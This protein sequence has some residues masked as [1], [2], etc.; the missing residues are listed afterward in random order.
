[1]SSPRKPENGFNWDDVRRQPPPPQGSAPARRSEQDCN[2][3]EVAPEQM[4][5]AQQAYLARQV[6][7][8][9]AAGKRAG[10]IG[11]W[12]R[13]NGASPQLADAFLAELAE[14]RQSDRWERICGRA[15]L[16]LIGGLS[17]AVLM[18]VM[19]KRPWD[20]TR[21]TWN[22]GATEIPAVA[23]FGL[24]C[25]L[26]LAA[27]SA[28]WYLAMTFGG[29]LDRLRDKHAPRGLWI[30]LPLVCLL[31]VLALA[32]LFALDPSHSKPPSGPAPVASAAE[33][34]ASKPA[35]E[36]P[37][38]VLTNHAEFN[39][40]TSL[41]GASAFLI[42]TQDGRTLAATAKHL[43]GAS[44][45]VEPDVSVA[46]LNGAI[47][48]WRM[49]PRTLPD[50][51]VSADKL[52]CDGL[53]GAD[54]DWLI[55]T[56]KTTRELPATLLRL[57]SEPARVGEKV[58]LVGCPYAEPTCRQNVYAGKVTARAGDR[59][60]YDI[61]P[62]VDLRGFSGAPIIDGNGHVLGVMTVWFEPKMQGDKFLEAGGEDAAAVF[63]LV[64]RQR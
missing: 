44:G 24:F 2:W 38:L 39:G 25:F 12:L 61:E 8:M 3:S 46:A 42:R 63:H 21:W 49:H 55:L 4:D 56:V 30:A 51:F 22:R 18:L 48:S 50:Q 1:M 17:V 11:N 14:S 33:E 59:F 62:P 40:H 34:W 9:R 41:R 19:E 5:P 64:E 58:F 13:Q 45:G 16:V 15:S 52:G 29:F 43:L 35:R 23:G 54:L 20:G 32:A 10:E 57:R 6:R 7:I 37:Q 60:R 31:V 53:T 26:Y 28:V 36:W 47:V 27:M